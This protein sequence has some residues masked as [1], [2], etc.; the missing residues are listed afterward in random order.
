MKVYRSVPVSMTDIP[1]RMNELES[2][3]YELGYMYF[4]GKILQGF[5]NTISRRVKEEGRY[6]FVFPEDALFFIYQNLKEA[7]AF[8]L[9]EF[10][11]P[12]EV[13][14]SLIGWG[15]YAP[16]GYQEDRRA[17]TYINKSLITGERTEGIIID[18]ETKKKLM[19]TEFKN[20]YKKIIQYRKSLPNELFE[21]KDYD[22][23]VKKVPS[24]YI[25]GGYSS[26]DD[27]TDDKVFE[28]IK[29]Q[30][31]FYCIDF[32]YGNHEII[33]TNSITGKSAMLVYEWARRTPP[34]LGKYNYQTMIESGFNLD[35]SKDGCKLRNDYVKLIDEKS[36]EEAK[37]LLKFRK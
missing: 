37:Q 7:E 36:Y 26:I 4:N 22:R 25:K 18:D 24:W 19:I 28:I 23:S 3:Y 15:G 27:I 32:L 33:K 21:K 13:V 29:S 6:F 30:S 16:Q 17:E 5:G 35:Y 10:D 34:E 31:E 1:V 11:F 9:M 8:K 2:L 20:A 12:E 14:Y